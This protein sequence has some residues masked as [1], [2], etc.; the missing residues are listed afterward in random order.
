[1][2]GGYFCIPKPEGT[3]TS[4]KGWQWRDGGGGASFTGSFFLS[5]IRPGGWQGTELPG[6]V[7]PQVWGVEMGTPGH[8]SSLAFFQPL[9]PGDTS[10]LSLWDC[11]ESCPRPSPMVVFADLSGQPPPLPLWMEKSPGVVGALLPGVSRGHLHPLAWS[12]AA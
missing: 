7:F 2:L 5:C 4:R 9:P 10:P 6:A 8:P 12:P 1:M 3:Q 11:S